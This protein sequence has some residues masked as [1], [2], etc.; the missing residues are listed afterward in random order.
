MILGAFLP[1]VGGPDSDTLLGVNWLGGTGAALCLLSVLCLAALVLS[2]SGA[3]G[4]WD[5]VMLLFSAL[6]FALI[7]Q[8]LYFLLDNDAGL[9]N[10][11]YG[12]WITLSGTGIMTLGALGEVV[13]K[14]NTL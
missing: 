6:A 10:I 14:N 1:Y 12:Y 4:R 2:R 9:D 11:G 3:S 8:F 5:Y 7:F 13:R